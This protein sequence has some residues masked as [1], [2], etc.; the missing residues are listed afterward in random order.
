MRRWDL[1]F[2]QKTRP[3]MSSAMSITPPTTAAAM[4]PVMFLEWATASAGSSVVTGLAEDVDTEVGTELKKDGVKL[5]GSNDGVLEKL[6]EMEVGVGAG[7]L[8]LGVFPCR[9]LLQQS[10]AEYVSAA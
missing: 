8:G 3:P 10:P 1:R 6:E 9:I 4:T 7:A 5:L 2:R